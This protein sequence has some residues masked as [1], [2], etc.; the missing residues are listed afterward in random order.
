MSK[1]IKKMPKDLE[2]VPE[3]SKA[4]DLCQAFE[5]EDCYPGTNI[6]RCKH[7]CGD[8]CVM[9]LIDNCWLTFCRRYKGQEMIMDM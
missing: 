9:L 8:S 6:P 7:L 1:Y 4:C 5:K 2:G 3:I